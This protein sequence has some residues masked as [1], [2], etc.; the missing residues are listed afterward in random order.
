MNC[1]IALMLLAALNATGSAAHE[2]DA[3]SIVQ[4]SQSANDIDWKA[5]PEYDWTERDLESDGSYKTFQEFMIL[6]SPYGKLIAINRTPLSGDKARDEE[7]KLDAEISKRRSET[8]EQRQKR[9]ADFEKERSREHAMMSQ[10]TVAFDF[11][12]IGAQRLG[13]RDVYV[14]EATPKRDYRPPNMECQALTGMR[15]RLRV[16]KKTFQWV[17][18][19]AEVVHPVSIEGILARV[20]PGTRFQLEKAPV[21]GDVWLPKHYSMRAKAKVLFMFT[22]KNRDEETYWDYQRSKNY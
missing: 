9:I 13:S 15:G 14:L 7:Q 10:L 5:N 16:D 6:G 19:E 18:V 3:K 20:E 22:H 4:H 17:K 1:G 21:E 8:P 11:K 2:P 12:L